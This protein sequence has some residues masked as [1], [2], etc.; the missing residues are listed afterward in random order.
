MCRC[1]M[2]GAA[3]A[4]MHAVEKLEAEAKRLD[5]LVSGRR[6]PRHGDDT[7]V[8]ILVLRNVADDLRTWS[9]RCK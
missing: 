8:R 5:A 1:R 2:E 7:Y 6:K 4:L 9:A 3:R